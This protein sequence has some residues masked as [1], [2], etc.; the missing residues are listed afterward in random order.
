MEKRIRYIMILA[1]IVLIV[2]GG[3]LIGDVFSYLASTLKHE[4]LPL[5][6]GLILLLIGL[7]LLVLMVSRH[8]RS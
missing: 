5:E 3:Y 1:S 7:G 2:I 8:F 6:S 4:V